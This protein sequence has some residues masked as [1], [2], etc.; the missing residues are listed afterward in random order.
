MALHIKQYMGCLRLVSSPPRHT[1]SAFVRIQ[2]FNKGPDLELG[3]KQHYQQYHDGRPK[4]RSKLSRHGL[5]G[6]AHFRLQC[7]PQLRVDSSY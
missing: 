3:G 4:R 5:V 7:L 2:L 6:K 1:H